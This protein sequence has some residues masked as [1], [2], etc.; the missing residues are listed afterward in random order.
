MWFLTSITPT[1]T[2]GASTKSFKFSESEFEEMSFQKCFESIS[3][4]EFLEIEGKRI[5]CLRSGKEKLR[6]P[7][8][9]FNCGSS[10]R[11]LLKDL[12]LSWPGRS[13][14]RCHHVRQIRR[15]ATNSHQV[16]EHAKPVNY[17][18]TEL[19]LK[20]MQALDEW[21]D[22]FLRSF[23]CNKSGRRNFNTW[24]DR[25]LWKDWVTVVKPGFHKGRHQ[26]WDNLCTENASNWFQMP[27][28]C[29]RHEFIIL[30][31]PVEHSC[32]TSYCLETS[33]EV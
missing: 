17:A 27:N 24:I 26:A 1:V 32:V 28:N 4:C 12:S 13:D 20:P 18:D 16:H 9:S 25:R 31:T 23:S 21:I 2:N 3:I 33:V 7:N 6:S 30:I 11:K 29:G 19:N 14:Q 10:Y 15:T 8:S 5:P 22:M